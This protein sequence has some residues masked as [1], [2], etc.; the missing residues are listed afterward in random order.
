[1][2]QAKKTKKSRRTDDVLSLI[3]GDTL[4]ARLIRMLFIQKDPLDPDLIAKAMRIPVV[5]VKKMLKWLEEDRIV[6]KKDSTREIEKKVRG[7][8]V[9]KTEGYVGYVPDP[10]CPFLPVLESLVLQTLPTEGS[11][12]TALLSKIPGMRVLVTTGIF[13]NAH[14]TNLDILIAG[15]NLNEKAVALVVRSIE[16]L[17]GRKIRCEILATNELVYRVN[18]HDKSIRDVLD[19]PHTVHFDKS[20]VL[21]SEV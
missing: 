20:G 6:T 3:I 18:V 7:E 12:F 21:R 19:Y 1:M 2:A 17:V 13:N 10:S 4:R 14:D 15:D 5:E 16:E 8:V 9:V 11:A